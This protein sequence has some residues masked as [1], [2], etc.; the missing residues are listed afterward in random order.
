MAKLDVV[1]IGRSSVT[2]DTTTAAALHP[3]VKGFAIGRTIF[4]DTARRWL[5]AEVT[6]TE[7]VSEMAGK[8]DRLCRLWDEARE[9]GAAA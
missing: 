7:A 5:A 8:Y 6:D 1:T 4:A 2:D 9:K 3:L